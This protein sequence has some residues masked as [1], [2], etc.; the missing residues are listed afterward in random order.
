[1]TEQLFER[2][3]IV[4][5]YGMDNAKTTT[6]LEQPIKLAIDLMRESPGAAQ[7]LGCPATRALEGEALT[8][9]RP[10]SGERR[11]RLRK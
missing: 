7:V 11:Q 9:A 8:I 2:K 5:I 4:S 3:D 1:M 10:E 6:L